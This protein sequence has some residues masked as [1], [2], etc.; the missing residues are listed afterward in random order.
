MFEASAGSQQ[1]RLGRQIRLL[2]AGDDDFRRTQ[3]GGA[4]EHHEIDQR[5]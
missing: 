2:G 4:A 5:I 1:A 3:A